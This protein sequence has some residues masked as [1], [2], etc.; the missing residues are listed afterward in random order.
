MLDSKKLVNIKKNT[1]ELIKQSTHQCYKEYIDIKEIEKEEH[2]SKMRTIYNNLLENISQQNLA[3]KIG[4][5]KSLGET[6]VIIYRECFGQGYGFETNRTKLVYEYDPYG[7]GTIFKILRSFLP[8]NY[9]IDF[10]EPWWIFSYEFRL[11][12]TWK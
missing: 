1:E 7:G 9:E 3:D 11:L 6:S 8:D 2:Q 4:R 12:I 10:Y 5:A